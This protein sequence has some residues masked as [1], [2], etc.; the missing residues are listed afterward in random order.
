VATEGHGWR[1]KARAIAFSP[2]LPFELRCR[3]LYWDKRRSW[4]TRRPATFTQK[5]LWKNVNDRRSLLTTFADKVAVRDYVAR[6]VGPEVLTQLH[7]VVHDPGGFDPDRL[8]TDFVVKPS[9]ASGLI[10]IVVDGATFKGPVSEDPTR[11]TSGLVTTRDALDWDLL[12]ATCRRW[13]ALSYADVELEWPYR[14]VPRRLLVEELLLEPEGRI[15]SDYKLWV[16]HGRV[17]LVEVHVD[18]FGDHRVAFLRPDWTMVDLQVRHPQ[19]KHT[20]PRPESFDRM[21][22]IAEVLG[23]E[24]DFVRVDL[25][26]VAGRIV[27]GELTSY[28]GGPHW[29]T[30]PEPFDAELGQ[31]WTV[32]TQYA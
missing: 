23:K 24:T 20:P 12:S 22:H 6:A 1:A 25:Y 2:R 10:R 30:F 31:Y 32:P 5:L 26:H 29:G 11:Q 13:L 19:A 16:F 15:P 18:R 21:V 28:P 4:S 17:R 14:H 27:F 9:H 3:L 7:A 8:P